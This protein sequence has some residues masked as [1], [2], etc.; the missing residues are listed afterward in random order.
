MDELR[1]AMLD[2]GAPR[3]EW[4]AELP[5]LIEAGQKR[6]RRRRMIAT[7]IAAAVVTVIGTTA[8]L[9]GVP[10]LNKSDPDPVKELPS[11]IYV[12][13]RI[14]PAEVERRCNIVLDNRGSAS[15]NTW[16]AG[17]DKNGRAVPASESVEPVE[18][19]VGHVVVVGRPGTKLPSN[20]AHGPGA[21]GEAGSGD[22]ASTY[23]TIPQDK[24][25]TTTG[26][27]PGDPVPSPDDRQQIADLCSRFGGYD[28]RGWDQLVAAE[29]EAVEAIFLSKN[30]YLLSCLISEDGVFFELD[31][32]RLADDVGKP[33]L[34]PGDTG[35]R[36]PDRYSQLLELGCSAGGDHCY[37][38][39]VLPGL[40]D[41][42]R[43]EVTLADG[44]V[45][46]TETK[47]GAYA[48]RV[49]LPAD[50]GGG[51]P[52]FT[53]K[54]LAPDGVVLWKGKTTPPVAGGGASG[55]DSYV[56]SPAVPPARQ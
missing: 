19:R 7:G 12:E 39:G 31:E 20:V 55:V 53:I 23:C 1:Q 37:M 34:P 3:D 15:S 2:A 10:G 30:G 26:R 46:A 45:R 13:E 52:E 22:E 49:D 25:L 4:Q 36:D 41:A 29:L 33:I 28:I 44:T 42:Y 35:P 6:V 8:A 48:I 18:N 17:V 51:D 11:G 50:G 21:P 47:R 40:P 56:Q 43:I 54:V 14:S 24:V 5:F 9:A 16:V 38:S 27:T 32:R